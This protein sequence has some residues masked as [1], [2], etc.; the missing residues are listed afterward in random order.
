MQN[1]KNKLS[2]LAGLTQTVLT[3]VFLAGIVFVNGFWTEAKASIEISFAY[4]LSNFSGPIPYNWVNLFVDEPRNEIYVVDPQEREIRV[5]NANGMEVFTFG[6]DGSLG[7]VFDVA[8]EKNG[9]ILVLSKDNSS[10][11]ILRCNFRGE[12]IGK[13][14]LSDFPSW[15]SDFSPTRMICRNEL[16]YLMDVVSMKIA[17]TSMDGLF[18]NGY[19]LMSLLEI[20]PDKMFGTEAGGFNVDGNGNM[21]FTVPVLFS[22]YTLSP[23]GELKGFGTPGSAPGR[24]GVVGGIAADESGNIFV[25]DRLR[26]VVLIFDS[27]FKFQKEFGYRG[28]LPDNLIS[29]TNLVIDGKDKLYVS[30]FRSRG[31]SVFKI[32]HAVPEHQ[33]N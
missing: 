28:S 25:A 33:A 10:F 16:L 32:S 19:D 14:T 27:Q 21:L 8:V 20:P 1:K 13:I 3:I 15:L 5:F 29:P 11:P 9:D 31:I 18:K 30:Q 2:A 17:V 12:V 23:E 6:D 7:A 26:S 24:F 4:S 22:A